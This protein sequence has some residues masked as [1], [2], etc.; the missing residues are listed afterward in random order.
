WPTGV[1]YPDGTSVAMSYDGEGNRISVTN[2]IGATTKTTFTV[3]DK[4]ATSTDAS[5]ATTRIEYNTQMEPVRLI[6]GDGNTWFY[7]YNRDGELAEQTD[8][9]G[10]TTKNSVS[11]DGLRQTVTTP[12]GATTRTSKS[13]GQVDTVVDALGTTSFVYDSVGRITGINGPQANIHYDHDDFGRTIR[14]TVI[15][16]SGEQFTHEIKRDKAGNASAELVTLPLGDT[17]TTSINRDQTGEITSTNLVRSTS[18]S[19]AQET[20]AHIGYGVNSCGIRNR[21]TTGSPVRNFSADSLGRITGD[22]LV[23]LDSQAPGGMRTLSSRLFTWRSDGALEGI[24]DYLRGVTTFDLDLNGRV[25]KLSR[26]AS[27]SGSPA[28]EGTDKHLLRSD[29]VFEYSDAGVLKGIGTVRVGDPYHHNPRKFSVSNLGWQPGVSITSEVDGTFEF[30]GTMPKRVGRTAYF[31]DEA[32][33]VIRTVTKNVSKKPT[34]HH[35]YYATGEQPIGFSSSEEPGVGYRYIYDPL[36]R[37]VAKERVD[38]ETGQLLT[39]TVFG[40]TGN[41]LVAQQTTYVAE[42]ISAGTAARVS[43][44]SATA[45]RQRGLN[46]PAYGAGYVWIT[47]PATGQLIGQVSLEREEHRDLAQARIS[48]RFS[49]IVTDLAGSPQE[50]VEP[51]EGVVTGLATQSLFGK[52]SW[53]G[54]ETCPLLFAGQYFDDESGWAY[55]RFRYYHPH[56]GMYNA[57]DPLGAYP[58]IATAQ[59]YVSHPAHWVDVLGL[60]SHLASSSSTSGID[61][62]AEIE[63]P[64]PRKVDTI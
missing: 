22:T 63:G 54:R 48:A 26:K 8:Y 2:E 49:L 36:G 21:I 5:G 56:A 37:R 41:Q 1:S 38:T 3:F 11:A 14:E 27:G 32:G 6:N 60:A 23:A 58:N 35:F 44:I 16:A 50:I 31:Y 47:D 17:F 4:P 62:K 53:R 29:E 61:V 19:D 15:L 45:N 30:A 46:Y 39:R 34:V 7:S 55:N 24:A 33:R 57:Q 13:N 28:Y 18:D 52:R 20:V 40:H 9:N 51:V 59:G 42:P 64:D 12:A 25:T 10:I 43:G